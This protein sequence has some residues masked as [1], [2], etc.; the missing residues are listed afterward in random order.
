MIHLPPILT[1]GIHAL[2]HLLLLIERHGWR[3]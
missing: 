2:G 1:S 3:L